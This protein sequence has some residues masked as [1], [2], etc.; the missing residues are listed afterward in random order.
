MKHPSGEYFEPLHSVLALTR[1]KLSKKSFIFYFSFSLNEIIYI[2]KQEFGETTVRF[3]MM[4]SS[5]QTLPAVIMPPY[6]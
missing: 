6:V 1:P 4:M 3:S 2:T 5:R